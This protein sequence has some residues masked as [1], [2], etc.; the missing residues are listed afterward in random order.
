MS[1]EGQPQTDV[2]VIGG[3]VIGLAIGWRAAQHGLQVVIAD[4][5]PGKGATHAAAGMLAPIA[6]AAYAGMT[7]I[8]FLRSAA[9]QPPSQSGTPDSRAIVLSVSRPSSSGDV[10]L[11]DHRS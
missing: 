2:L 4:P 1:V 10:S 9:H 11:I 3:G 8:R 6:E 5:D 7:R